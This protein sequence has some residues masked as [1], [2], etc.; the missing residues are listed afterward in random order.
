MGDFSTF[1]DTQ[2]KM[3]ELDELDELTNKFTKLNSI[4]S[5]EYVSVTL[6]CTGVSNDDDYLDKKVRYFR[7]STNQTTRW[8]IK[9][10]VW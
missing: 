4:L 6:A 10:E 1:L 5:N 8:K 7:K 2:L 3:Q 9:I